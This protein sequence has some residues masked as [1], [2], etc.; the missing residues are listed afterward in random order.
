MAADLIKMQLKENNIKDLE[1]RQ[2][3]R[4]LARMLNSNSPAYKSACLKCIKKLL[5]YTQIVKQL[6][7]DSV[8][9]PL[10]LGL[11]SFVGWSLP[12]S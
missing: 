7:S 8:V 12:A 1:D 5:L 4:R 9:L 11:I 2:F 10:L 6:L 3:I